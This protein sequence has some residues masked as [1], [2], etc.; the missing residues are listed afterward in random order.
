MDPHREG[1]ELRQERDVLGRGESTG[2]LHHPRGQAAHQHCTTRRSDAQSLKVAADG[3]A[4]SPPCK[5]GCLGVYQGPPQ[6][7]EVATMLQHS[8]SGNVVGDGDMPTKWMGDRRVDWAIH[9]DGSTNQE[10]ECPKCEKIGSAAK[11]GARKTELRLSPR[12]ERPLSGPNQAYGTS[13]RLWATTSCGEL[14]PQ[15]RPKSHKAPQLPRPIRTS[16]RNAPTPVN[17]RPLKPLQHP[18]KHQPRGARRVP[19]TKARRMLAA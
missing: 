5:R 8:C 17:P 3:A 4:L 12:P 10:R 15:T 16:L 18:L 7:S 6:Q 2:A 14:P 13:G 19:Q 1:G 9:S 11:L